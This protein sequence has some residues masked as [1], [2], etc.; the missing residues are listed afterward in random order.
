M[1]C[2]S[3]RRSDDVSR[4]TRPPKLRTS[5]NLRIRSCNAWISSSVYLW[6]EMCLSLLVNTSYSAR[7]VCNS[8]YNRCNSSRSFINKLS[9]SI[10]S[11]ELSC[12]EGLLTILLARS[13]KRNVFNVSVRLTTHGEIHTT[14]VV[15]WLPPIESDK[16]LVRVES[17]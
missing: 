15:L 6:W 11:S 16:S 5:S 1:F 7:I 12:I 8:F 3:E 13:A 4:R 9:L 14:I 17:R 10:D 2:Y